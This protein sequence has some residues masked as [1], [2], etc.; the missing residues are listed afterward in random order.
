MGGKSFK[1]AWSAEEIEKRLLK[2]KEKEK[3][4]GKDL[5]NL[6]GGE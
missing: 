4:K 3:E 1:K 6:F 2:I 5:K